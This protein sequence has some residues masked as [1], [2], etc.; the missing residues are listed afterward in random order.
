M[1]LTTVILLVSFLQISAKSFSQKITMSKKNRPIQEALTEIEKQTG[2]KF[3][4]HANVLSNTR[5]VTIEVVDEPLPSVLDMFLKDQG[6]TWKLI[7]ET[8]ILNKAAALPAPV[9]APPADTVHGRVVDNTGSPVPGATV[10]VKGVKK[11]AITNVNGEFHLSGIPDNAVLVVSN[12]GF[13]TQEV[14]VAGKSSLT[15]KFLPEVSQLENVVVVGYGTQKK[16]NLT[17]SV[18][19]VSGKVLENR[20]ITRISQGLQGMVAGLNITTNTSGG[21]PNATQNINVRGY[22]GLNATGGPLVVIDGIQGGDINAINPSDVESISVLKDAASTAIYGSSAPYG[23]IL[24]TTKKGK[25]GMTKITYDD[26]FAWAQT[27]NL[28][29]MLNSL[30]FANIY[31]E[32]FANAGRAPFFSQETIDRIK[33]YQ[34]GTITTQTIKD[35]NSNSWLNWNAGNA[36]ND[37]FKIYFKKFA[38]SQQHNVGISGATEKSN[39]Y[40]GIGYND[41]AGMYNY[42]NDEFK[43]FNIRANLTSNVTNWMSFTLRSTI[44]RSMFNTPNVYSG[45]TGGNYMHQIARKFP[46][47]SLI[48]PDGHYSAESNVPLHQEGGRNKITEDQ[49]MLTGEI[50]LTPLKGWEIVGNYTFDGDLYDQ[51]NQLKT[52]YTYLPDGSTAPTSGTTPNSFARNNYRNE[53]HI[54]NAYSSYEKGFG[55]HNFRLLGGFTS[56]LTNY[57]AYGASNSLLYS[58]DIPSLSLTYNT[59][60]SVSD[61]IRRLAVEGFFGRFNYNYADKYLLEVNGRYDGTSRF[62]AGHRWKFSPGVSAGWNVDREPFWASLKEV[63]N[64]FKIRGSYGSSPDQ[65]FLGDPAISTYY[66]FYPSL[67]TTTPTNTSWLFGGNKQASVSMP[68]LVNSNLTWVT[69]TSYGI[70]TDIGMLNNRLGVNFDYYIRKADDFAGPAQV[71]PGLLGSSV[72][73]INNAAIQTKGFELTISWNDKI[74]ELGY[75]VRANLSDYKG[76][77]VKY[78][79][80]SRTL[81]TWYEGQTMGEIWG[82]TTLGLYATD[83]DAAKAPKA[84]FWNST[85]HAGDVIYKDF[86]GNGIINNGKNT[87]DSSGDLRVIGNNTPRYQYSLNLNF[88]Y[89]GF[90][91]GIFLQGVAKRDA[92][93]GSNYFWGIVGDEWQS[94]PFTAQMNRWTPTNQNGYFPKFYMS[95]EN[96]KNTQVQTRYLQNAAY[97]RIKNLQLGYTLPKYMITRIHAQKVRV[98]MSVE[99][100]ATFT[101]LIKTV[102]PELSISD[103]KIYPLQRTYSCGINIIL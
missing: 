95:G 25:M 77:V 26:N 21:A 101:K 56:E 9:A 49:P 61:Q 20:P 2:Y 52:V 63:V 3:W 97:L 80:P 54:I 37:W 91:L 14:P 83:A 85:W 30:D 73:K 22:T 19:Q 23:V 67:G 29:K 58:N 79:N 33:A 93:I 59:T 89:K 81:D 32:A 15:I 24:I 27:I 65:L 4:Y 98:Y 1:K 44:S 40:I 94:S 99:N 51:Q 64:A 72:P 39:Y 10:M 36:N 47:V 41:H 55:H 96:N 45:Q 46:T 42:G 103:S 35:P 12:I 90:D 68:P 13:Q 50:R 102:D 7:R 5:N 82:Y 75:G 53:H 17:G 78:N 92:W 69:T 8:I 66:P 84:S 28:P 34:A 6:L 43:R 60:P 86:D 11:A 16:V 74:G 57:T 71:L 38:F 70:G 48:N 18:A 87:V 31:N 100:L 62:L 76:K 88:D